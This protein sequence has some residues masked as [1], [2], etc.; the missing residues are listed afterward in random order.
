[1][2]DRTQLRYIS[3]PD[4]SSSDSVLVS[5]NYSNGDASLVSHLPQVE[6]RPGENISL[7]VAPRKAG[8]VD[9]LAVTSPDSN[10]RWGV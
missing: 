7:T 8:H 3:S 9:I 4:D 2:K 1:M 10:V 6:L 5:F